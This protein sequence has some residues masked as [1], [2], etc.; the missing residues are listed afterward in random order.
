M[1]EKIENS[2][3]I[4]IN[5][6]ASQEK[7]ILASVD[8]IK[9]IEN[10]NLKKACFLITDLIFKEKITN[11]ISNFEATFNIID[12]D[13]LLY[14]LHKIYCFILSKI[15][16]TSKEKQR[17]VHIINNFANDYASLNGS[18]HIHEIISLF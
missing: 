3:K 11:N 14:G 4:L 1:E 15:K 7:S 18:I 16:L 10:M 2:L 13:Y 8:F 9:T 17:I 12:F 5:K 6:S